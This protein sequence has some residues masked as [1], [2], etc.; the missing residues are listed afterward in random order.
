MY[1]G[2]SSSSSSTREEEKVVCVGEMRKHKYSPITAGAA[3]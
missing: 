2:L 3:A 1:Y